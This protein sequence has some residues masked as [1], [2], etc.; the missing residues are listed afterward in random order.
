MWRF[1]N[2]ILNQIFLSKKI[3]AVNPA[4][5]SSFHN[6]LLFLKNQVSAY[7]DV[8]SLTMDQGPRAHKFLTQIKV[9]EGLSPQFLE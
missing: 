4:W 3:E 6:N 5:N 8:L 9:K 2:K 1:E 7:R